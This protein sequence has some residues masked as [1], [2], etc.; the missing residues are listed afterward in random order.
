MN[1]SHKSKSTMKAS[2]LQIFG[3][4]TSRATEV[5]RYGLRAVAQ[6]A[7][8]NRVMLIALFSLTLVTTFFEGGTIALLTLAVSVLVQDGPTNFG[9]KFGYLGESFD[10]WA[11]DKEQAYLFLIITLFA[12]GSQLLRSS[13]VFLGKVFSIN[14][15]T[16]IREQ[17]LNLATSQV[18]RFN[19]SEVSKYSAGE[20]NEKI[21]TAGEVS[22]IVKSCHDGLLSVL[23]LSMYLGLMLAMSLLLTLVSLALVVTLAIFLALIIKNLRR[24]GGKYATATVSTSSITIEFLNAARLLRI[25]GATQYAKGDIK[26]KRHVM[27]ETL[28]KAHV[29]KGSISP[30]VEI[31]TVISFALFLIVGFFV[32][33]ETTTSIP[34]LFLFVL[35]LHRAMPQVQN[36]GQVA[37]ALAT[38][39]GQLGLVGELMRNDDKEF[40]RSGGLT[41]SEIKRQIQIQNL[42]F[43]HSGESKPTLQDINF[44]LNHGATIGVVGSS[45]TGK[46]TLADLVLG[47]RQPTTG[48]I[49]I[50]G[51]GLSELNQEEWLR[52]VGVV[53]QDIFLLND[54]IKRNIAFASEGLA[55]D[56]IISAAKLANAHHF[57][58]AFPK[59]YDTIIGDRGIRLS[60]GQKQRLAMARALARNPQL[61]ILDEATSA[62][63]SESERLIQK[64]VTALKGSRS[65]LVIAHRLSTVMAADEI[66]VLDRGKIVEHGRPGDLIDRGGFFSKAWNIQT[67]TK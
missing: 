50:D 14:V 29:V 28:R 39:L 47:L 45:G 10:Q 15:I 66:I 17:L 46:S 54:T 43:V 61:L 7:F 38:T 35:V 27:L 3:F 64:T 67:Q 2:L 60:G 23:M 11:I 59:G 53:D 65:I 51:V 48:R 18:M 32:L 52:I 4:L 16:R 44:V 6:V 40:I 9:D 26:Q 37:A 25:F 58:E 19:F 62:L 42:S 21:D 5:N 55:Q 1:I 30:I 34:T 56:S 24:L 49:L 22:R 8:R 57:I 31:V 20:L 36:L 33:D 41:I 63:D 12:V 13:L